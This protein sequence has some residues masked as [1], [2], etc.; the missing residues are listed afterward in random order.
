VQTAAEL[1][2]E[3]SARK[4]GVQTCKVKGEPRS[5]QE[6]ALNA[7]SSSRKRM[8][9]V[10]RN[11]AGE[12]W[13]LVKGAD[14]VMLERARNIPKGLGEQIDE[15]AKQGLRTL[16]IGRRR[17]DEK[18]LP[19]WLEQHGAALK[20]MDGR[21]E[22]LEAAAESIER[23]LE[24]LGAT[25]IEDKLQ[26]DVDVTISNLK[27]A[28][29]KVWVLTGDKLD[30]ARIIGFSCAVLS[31]EMDIL[32]L[33]GPETADEIRVVLRD[34]HERVS[35]NLLAKRESALM[36]TGQALGICL[37]DDDPELKML[38]LEVARPCVV[39]M[40]CRVSPSQKADIVR[41][42]RENTSPTPVTL[43]IGDGANDVPMIQ[44]AQVGVGISGKE[45]KQAANAAD[46][47]IG[48]FRFL[49]R[50][51]LVHG[52]WNY[53]RTCKF[54]LYSFYKNTVLVLTLFAYSFFCGQSG[55][56]FY[57]DLVRNS[58]NIILALPIICVGVFEQ[59]VSE[60]VVLKYP[61]LYKSGRLGLDLNFR[62]LAEALLSAL[63]HAVI[64]VKVL[65]AAMPGMSTDG[66]GGYYLF[67]TAAFSCLIM[68]MNYRA[69]FL[70]KTWNWLSLSA[71]FFGSFGLY[72]VF[73]TI[74]GLMP[75]SNMYMVPFKVATTP[76]FW[77]V[78]IVV[79]LQAMTIDL[80]VA[81]VLSEFWPSE[82]DLLSEAD[83]FGLSDAK[84]QS[85]VDAINKEHKNREYVAESARLR[86][87]T[88]QQSTLS[89]R[90]VET[91]AMMSPKPPPSSAALEPAVR[92]E[93][94]SRSFAFSHPDDVR[95]SRFGP[96]RFPSGMFQKLPSLRSIPHTLR[97]ALIPS[98]E[99]CTVSVGPVSNE[100]AD[101]AYLQQ[102]LPSKHFVLT[103]FF[104]K[105][106]LLAI[107]VFFM[108]SGLFALLLSE[109]VRQVRVQ[110][111]GS[112]VA[113]EEKNNG[114]F[115]KL[116]F[117]RW[118]TAELPFGTD[119]QEVH[120]HDCSLGKQHMGNART[121]TF[122]VRVPQDMQ[123]PINVLYLVSPFLQNYNR[124]MRSVDVRQL[125]GQDV[126]HDKV[127]C[128]E[129]VTDGSGNFLNPCGLQAQ[130][131]FNDT[132]EVYVNGEDK[133]AV[134]SKDIVF[135]SQLHK[136]WANPPNHG[137]DNDRTQWLHERYPGVIKREDDVMDPHFM[138]HMRPGALGY[139]Q[140]KYGVI[141]Q[142]LRAGQEIKIRVD[143]RFPV[144]DF[145]GRKFLILTT[146]SWLG[147]RN[148]FLGYELLFAAFWVLSASAAVAFQQWHS[149]RALGQW[150]SGDVRPRL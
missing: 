79:P 128:M 93:E 97:T 77:L 45:G 123:P 18:E 94:H 90:D 67:G 84:M 144:E 86:S 87:F 124:Y 141:N 119:R 13:L 17:L 108:C 142:P 66:L 44:E 82:V 116:L 14:N 38:L 114:A 101:V 122:S 10:V 2:W 22:M 32:T 9:L 115:L 140:K 60:E 19:V 111:D 6:L 75:W 46:F 143:A 110:Y 7:F 50:L 127:K 145:D 73:I 131:F 11:Q 8:S 51:L 48:Q 59:D 112:P 53:R 146:N 121:C 80:V 130:S 71:M 42:V 137:N 33:D 74:Y 1:G 98:S 3:F 107:G 52:R 139:A 72:I 37:E 105:W 126:P 43:S 106:S 30:T 150:R 78:L 125:T 149:P 15:F 57:E 118:T 26:E 134:D 40:A 23:D 29:V 120:E 68:A 92:H 91:P 65:A 129:A 35:N 95:P 20:C 63:L 103:G 12:A 16:V 56:S 147:G 55:T 62:K 41:L 4:A 99:D 138:V 25:A 136:H 61:A 47:S 132:F 54:I 49:Q 102:T 31:H 85:R 109:Q 39:L 135:P 69:A 36:V 83:V 64:L 88:K 113:F 58:F 96:V 34:F 89:A 27:Q 70:T 100:P 104:V 21:Q 28:G 117:A 5:Y 148:D 133:S 81:Y 76:L 24:L